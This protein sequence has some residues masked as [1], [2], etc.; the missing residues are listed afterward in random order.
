MG[1]R[2]NE[3]QAKDAQ[4]RARHKLTLQLSYIQKSKQQVCSFIHIPWWEMCLPKL[5][6]TIK[7]LFYTLCD[8]LR[9]FAVRVYEV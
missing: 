2:S 1:E 8:F 7:G 9:E 6:G 3:C 5:V 4:E